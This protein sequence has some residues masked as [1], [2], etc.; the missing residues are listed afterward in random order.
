MYYTRNWTAV[1]RSAGMKSKSINRRAELTRT[2]D[3]YWVPV[4]AR[5]IDI[6]DSFVSDSDQLTLE[7]IV[8]RTRVPHTTAYR[9]LHTL[10]SRSYLLQTARK[11]RLNR[12]RKRLKLGFANLSKHISLAVDIQRSLEK[13]A[14][15][16][17]VQLNVWDND[18]NAETAIKNAEEMVQQKIDVAIEFQLFEQVAPIIADIFSRAQIP[19]ISIVNPHHGTLY[20]GVNNYRAGFSAGIA[21]ADHA[22]TRWRRK[23]DAVL[24]LESPHAGRT[25]QSRLIGVLRGLEERL[26]PMKNASVAHLDCGGDRSISRRVVHEFLSKHSARHALIAAINDESAIGAVDAAKCNQ[27]CEI[28]IV[29]H[30]GSEEMLTLVADPN[31]HC[32]GTVFFHAELYGPDLIEFALMSIQG[33]APTATHYVSH[34]FVGKKEAGRRIH[35]ALTELSPA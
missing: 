6:L 32:I 12:S 30:G 7:E 16:A 2:S 11:Y 19:L 24:L 29:G 34:E 9:I 17:G 22:S 1:K 21:L 8:Q 27:D 31:S 10:V 18:R 28:G 13:S 35:N 15:K 5:T 23:P 33:V 20:F 26:G 25:V 4:V 14:V 3:K